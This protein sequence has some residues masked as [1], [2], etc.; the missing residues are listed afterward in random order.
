MNY[1]NE[2]HFVTNQKAYM[3]VSFN[4]KTKSVVESPQIR[5]SICIWSTQ[6]VCG[7]DDLCCLFQ[8]CEYN[9]WLLLQHAFE[10]C[11]LIFTFTTSCI[12]YFEW[13]VCSPEA[14][15]GRSSS[16]EQISLDSELFILP[17]HTFFTQSTLYTWSAHPVCIL[18]S[19]CILYPVC[20][21]H[22][23]VCILN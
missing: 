19:V 13:L 16:K 9:V 15:S 3:Y 20:S 22:S 1:F 2:G 10:Q 5:Y 17:F 14:R 8:S 4:I 23:A 18:C 11:Y 21:L 12:V 6:V 7:P